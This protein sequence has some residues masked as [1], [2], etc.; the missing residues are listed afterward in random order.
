M[1]TD[2]ADGDDIE[3]VWHNEVLGR[4]SI[5]SVLFTPGANTD[6]TT[7]ASMVDW[8]NIGNVT[9]PTWATTAHIILSVSAVFEITA[10][11][12]L[13]DTRVV[14]GTD[15]GRTI[16]GLHGSSGVNTRY[17]NYTFVDAI[18]LTATGSKALKIQALRVAGTGAWR[19]DSSSDF[20]ARVQFT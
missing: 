8:I 7:G 19:A 4:T 12:N 2:V 20:C 3:A 18:P 17:V 16:E 15:V 5:A 9:V 1:I 13:Y 14:I 10:A 6:A 11:G